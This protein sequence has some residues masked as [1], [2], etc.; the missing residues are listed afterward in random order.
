MYS[1]NKAFR[2]QNCSLH[3]QCCRLYSKI[4]SAR[5]LISKDKGLIVGKMVEISFGAYDDEE[6]TDSHGPPN[7]YIVQYLLTYLYLGVSSVILETESVSKYFR[8]SE[9]RRSKTD[10]GI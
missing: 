10:D 1:Q 9:R 6:A 8:Q 2:R 7:L 3:R 4:T 5:P